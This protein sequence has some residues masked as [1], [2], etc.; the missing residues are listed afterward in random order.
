MVQTIE[1]PFNGGYQPYVLSGDWVWESGWIDLAPSEG[2]LEVTFPL[3]DAE[4]DTY[5]PDAIQ[6]FGLQVV[7]GEDAPV[8]IVLDSVTVQ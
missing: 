3:P 1:A 7:I 5:F 2:T 4:T 8:H 6:T